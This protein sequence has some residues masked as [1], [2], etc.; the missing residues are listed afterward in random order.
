MSTI[1]AFLH[2]A[3][4]AD[5]TAQL[6]FGSGNAL[7]LADLQLFGSTSGTLDML[8]AATTTPYTITWP[9]AQGTGVLTN[10]GSGILSWASGGTVTSISIASSNGFAGSSSGGSTPILTLQTS[11][12]SPVLAG[13][14]TALIAATTTGTG[15]T[16][17]LSA[18]PTFT[19]TVS[20]SSMSLSA[21]L[22]M[23]SNQINGLANGTASTDA[24][25]YGQL[26][27]V[28][29]G[30]S[31]KNNVLVAT[32][33]N[34]TLSGEQTIDGFLTSASR[35]LVKN[36][37][38]TSQN[39]IYV[40]A[41]GA[42]SRSTDMNTWAQVP[43]TV[44]VAEEGTVNGDLAFICTAIVGGTLG[45]TAITFSS[46]GTYLADDT[47]LTLT[48]NV[49]SIAT[50]G[51]GTSQLAAAAV[52]YAKIQNESASTLLGNPT[53]GSASPSEIGL[54]TTL[55]FVG[56]SLETQAI[57]GDVT[58][59]ANS[60]FTT[61][62][63][64]NGSPGTFTNATVTVNAK[65]LVTSA[66]SGPT[67]STALTRTLVAGQ[68]FTANTSYAVRWG[69]VSDGGTYSG[70]VYAADPTTTSH[71]LFYVIG[72]ASSA[73]TVTAGS[74]ITVTTIGSFTLSSA[75]TAF[76]TGTDGTAVFLTASGTFSLTA[77]STS[78]QAITRIG[79]VQVGSATNT[80]CIIDVFPVPVGV[81]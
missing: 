31:W 54:G 74:N 53:G 77:P 13:N 41:A 49:F 39:G 47:T 38:T 55:T 8:A 37:T 21:A 44:V 57:S 24:A 1:S 28:A 20:A 7:G 10:N 67:T 76:G 78:G 48:G 25:N 69:V 36:Q 73:T 75:D 51:V 17:V 46:F 9:A 42:W 29:A 81:N 30:L 33:A 66:S 4:G 40:S 23:N 65:G 56:T 35:V 14:G 80:S 43:G 6:G 11:I 3:T 12:N 58:S 5:R 18:S 79:M 50:G 19:G 45:T 15:S 70:R 61:L 68:T 62:A 63:T 22:N 64:V 52:T 16:V 60:F 71:D 72:M 26:L 2:L 27:A 34:I 32:T 59:P